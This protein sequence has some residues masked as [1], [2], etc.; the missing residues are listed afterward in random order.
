MRLIQQTEDG[1]LRLTN[2][3]D[4]DIPKYA[5]LSHTW[6]SD[7]SE[8]TFN[9][10]IEDNTRQKVSSFEKIRF[11]AEEAA[12]DGLE[13]SWVDTCCIDKSN[14]VELQ[15]AITSMFSWYRNAAKCYVYLSD[16][17]VTEDELTQQELWESAFRNSRWFTRGW[18]LQELLAPTSVEFFSVEGRRLGDRRSLEVV[19]HEITGIPYQALRGFD[20]TKFT[21]AER[22]SWAANRQTRRKED[23]AYSM[24]GLCN[25]FMP[26]IYGEGT[27][28]FTRLQEEIEKKHSEGTRQNDLLSR[29]PV[30]PQAAFNSLENQHASTCLPDTRVE[31]LREITEWVD[32]H[33]KSCIFWLNGLAGTG[34]STIA[35]TMARVFHNRGSLGASFFFSR[36][37][38]DA[39]QADRLFTSLAWQLAAKI[40]QVKAFISEAIMEQ[41]NIMDQ[42]LR[43]QWDQ[44]ILKPLSMLSRKDPLSTIVIVLDALDECDSDRD[45]RIVLRL[46]ASCKSLENI[47][48]RV[49]ISSRPDIAVR[50][51]FYQLPLAERQV[52]VLHD[53][54]PE[55]VDHDLGLFFQHSLT[56]IREERG[57][58]EDWPGM[59]II[60]ALVKVSGGLFIWAATACRFIRDGRGLAMK[61]IHNLLSG[62]STGLG[63]E[64]KLDEI[65]TIVLRDCIQKGGYNAEEKQE[66]CETLREVLGNIVILFSP[67]SVDSL[68]N[69]LPIS[70]S[71]I[72]ETLADCH[73]ILSI[74]R[75]MHRPI[76]LHHPTF[77]DF[78]LDKNRC[79]DSQF[80]V[81]EK[82]AHKAMADNCVQLMLKMLKT[83]MCNLQS[84]GTL[85]KEIDPARIKERIPPELE[86]A[87]RYWAQHYRESGTRLHDGDLAHRFIQECFLHWLELMSLK[88]HVS[89]VAGILRMYQALLLV[90]FLASLLILIQIANFMICRPMTIH[91]S[92]LSSRMQDGL[93]CISSRSLKWRPFRRIVPLLPFA[94]PVIKFDVSSGVKCD[95]GFQTFESQNQ[96]TTQ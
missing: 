28:A 14:A 55:I 82:Q 6:L 96:Q 91:A 79:Y 83:D 12:K 52:F 5:I 77:R 88:K 19:I 95:A 58:S 69:L 78:L 36:G 94:S 65:Y 32:G 8:V 4:D 66:M 57:F 61:R 64:V 26:L 43:D 92:T 71:N 56:T 54:Q 37:G 38:G 35:R 80:W 63:P 24:L 75:E 53:I 86:Y 15:E 81:D 90:R 47:R 33:E 87:G 25:V 42:S 27:N 17:S 76:R 40:P 3:L 10:V 29:L 2:F 18:T 46:L 23:K 70:A 93:H 89:E 67:L 50:C 84:T 21:M 13:Y 62:R 41:E 74:P 20:T 22:L 11:C 85:V 59:H 31:L 34:K 45:I 30:V 7:T 73:T 44:L 68:S 39:S 60:R 49:L 1:G 9:D 51:S 16:V 72:K 48:L